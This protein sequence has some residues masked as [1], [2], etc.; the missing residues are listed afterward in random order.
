MAAGRAVLLGLLTAAAAS[1]VAQTFRERVEVELVR[2]ELLATDGKGH[3]VTRLRPT[4]VHVKVDGRPVTIESLEA[5]VPSLPELPAA[6]GPALV[7]TAPTAEAAPLSTP[8]AA[9]PK[10]YLAVLADETSSEQSNRQVAYKQLFDFLQDPLPPD[11]KVLLMRFD[12]TLHVECPWTAD[13]ERVRRTVGTMSQHRAAPLLG[14]P[15]QLSGNPEQGSFNLQLEAMEAIVHVRS[16]LAGLF[17]ALRVFP[18]SR[19]R[20]ALF[21]VTDGAPFLAPS[22][23]A[24]ELIATSP[25]GGLAV[26][27]GGNE[28]DYD[29]DLLVDSL[30]WNRTRSA[31]LLKEIAQLALL[32]GIEIHPVRTA[33]HD[34][35]GRVRTD[36]AFHERALGGTVRDRRSLRN[37][38]T[39]P[40]TD[41]AAGQNMERMAETTG[42]EAILSRRFFDDSL[43]KEIAAKDAACALMFRDPYKGDHRFHRIDISIDRPGAEL[44]YRRGYRILDVREALV[45]GVANRLHLSADQNPL[46]VRL[47]VESLGKQNGSAVAEITVAYPAP[48]Q[49]GGGAANASAA[50]RV[51]GI[52][53]VRNGRL[54]EPI[55]FSGAAEATFLD[56]GTWLVRSGRVKVK[57]GAYRWSFAVRDE[58]TGITSYL[59]FDRALP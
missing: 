13:A 8:A 6:R 2:V 22:E 9:R 36:R 7:P 19:G 12:G 50:V 57:P 27:R 5:P 49:A 1:V 15:G 14:V 21:V 28:I 43:R 58:Q 51:V 34:F 16:S 41:I 32:R 11:I 39:I 31:S 38:D 47:Q 3:A 45:E 30:A 54:S 53:A 46:G 55:D 35:D 17:D 23:V 42:G 56:G 10:Y 24:K 18:E 52:C 48:P 37:A 29:R 59:T 40:T 44:R 25:S 4:E 20:K 33:P 26:P